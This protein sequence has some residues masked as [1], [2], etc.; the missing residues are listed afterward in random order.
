MSPLAALAFW[1]AAFVGTHLLMSHPLRAPLVGRLGERGFSLLYI[2]V[3]LGTFAMMVRSAGAA[4]PQTPLW[5]ASLPLWVL[6][7]IAMWFGAILFVGSLRRNPAFPTGGKPVTHIGEARGVYAITRH[8]M[9]WG[10]ALWAM[11]HIAV[12]PTGSGLIIATAIL[13]LALAGSAG[14]DA[15]KEKLIGE[16]W[17]E[18]KRRTSFLPFGRG[19][20][21]PDR[22]AFAGG[23][24]LFVLATWGH[25]ALGTMAAGP[26]RWLV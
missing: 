22:F 3:S 18:W 14:Q 4:G 16:P 20:G 9:M 19:A 8:P 13:I 21:R 25:G 26:W 7:S 5:Q 17:T 12:W 15:K 11:V 1:A 23:T 2:A 6:A 24:I 10:F